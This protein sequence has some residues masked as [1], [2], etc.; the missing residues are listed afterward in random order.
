MLPVSASVAGLGVAAVTTAASFE[1]SMSQVQSTMRYYQGCDVQGR[2][3]NRQHHGYLISYL[4]N[5]DSYKVSAFDQAGTPTE[6]LTTLL[7]GTPF[8]VGTV[9]F[10]ESVTLRANKETT[11]RACHLQGLYA[12]LKLLQQARLSPLRRLMVLLR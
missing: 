12:M 10:T 1:S 6:I 5:N 11:R 2:W 3:S 9:D 7:Q 4:L 8:S